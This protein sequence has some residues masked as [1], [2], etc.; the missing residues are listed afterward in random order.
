MEE[1]GVKLTFCLRTSTELGGKGT[2]DIVRH[3]ASYQGD[4]RGMTHGSWYYRRPPTSTM[5]PCIKLLVFPH[6]Y[7]T[8]DSNQLDLDCCTQ[9]EYQPTHY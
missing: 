8:V 3:P 1:I 5:L 6:I 4:V 7:C 2:L 9:K